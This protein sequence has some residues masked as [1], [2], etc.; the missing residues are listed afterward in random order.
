MILSSHEI[1]GAAL[2]AKIFPDN[3]AAAFLIG[4]TS[5]F[6]IDLIPH[7]D[8]KLLSWRIDWYDETEGDMEIG[9]DFAIDLLRI[10]ADI[11]FG[12]AF[13]FLIFPLSK[14]I[15]ALSILSGAFGAIL[16]D[17]FQFIY[18]KFRHQPF[19]WLQ[20][21]HLAS[22]GKKIFR[23]RPIIGFIFQFFVVIFLSV[24]ILAV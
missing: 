22:H 23:G 4:F 9:R 2:A 10:G 3:P 6:L 17:G 20:R 11:M 15:V 16:P 7:W 8:Y 12:L 13:I 24:L 1:I 19:I 18:F 14:P 5:H 21:F